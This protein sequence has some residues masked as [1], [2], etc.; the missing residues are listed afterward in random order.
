M[1][2][3]PEERRFYH[4]R[5]QKWI[6][7]GRNHKDRQ[8]RGDLTTLAAAIASDI[9]KAL[10][11]REYPSIEE[12]RNKLPPEVRDMAPLFCQREADKLLPHRPGI[13][14]RIDLRELP[15]G[16]LPTLP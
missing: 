13:D 7:E 11:T 4:G 12:L 2:T 14:H 1:R 15:D 6:K 9:E 3:T 5:A 8:D 16:S 10:Q